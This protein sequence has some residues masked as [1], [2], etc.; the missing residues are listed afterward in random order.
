MASNKPLLLIANDDG[1]GAKGINFLVDTLRPIADIF[2]M[3]PDSPRSGAG[4]S[5]TAAIPIR[6]SVLKQEEG[7]TVCSCSGTPVDCVKLA[8]GMAMPQKPDL[9]VSGI[10]HG[11]NSSV[12]THYSG[13]MGAALE[14]AMQGLPSIA[15]SLCDTSADADFEPLKPYLVD[16]VFKAIT[17]GMPPSVC[18]NVNF[19]KLK[20]FKGVKACRMANARWGEE[21]EPRKHPHGE[22]Y[23]WLSGS[24]HDLEP[25]EATDTDH[26]ALDHGYVAVT[27]TQVDM[28]AY[29]MIEVLKNCL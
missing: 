15:F 12:N 11:D 21:I 18:L 16:L 26:W 25:A 2:V 17:M 9:V 22:P 20:K 3:A 19:P 7:L 27:P 29:D 23:Y 28:T 10:N 14:G 13:T 24:C 1:V 4:C 6:Y 8:L 5:I